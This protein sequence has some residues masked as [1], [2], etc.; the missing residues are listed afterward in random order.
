MV[1]PLK[2]QNWRK[3]LTQYVNNTLG[4]PFVWGERDCV[5]YA[6]GAIEAMIGAEVNKPKFNYDSKRT[7]LVFAQKYKLADGMREQLSAYDVR[8]GFQQA[9]DIAIVEKDGF[10]CCHVVMGP[11]A[12]APAFIEN[13]H[14]CRF[15]MAVLLNLH[16][17]TQLLRFD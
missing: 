13:G 4:L 7:A 16:P 17:D 8:H 10:E 11:S 6:I 12:Y 9:G 15:N 14:V 5:T 3:A 1:V 2:L